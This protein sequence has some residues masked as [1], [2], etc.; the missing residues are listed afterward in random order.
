MDDDEYLRYFEVSIVRE[1]MFYYAD[2]AM[3]KFMIMYAVEHDLMIGAW[4]MLVCEYPN[5]RHF[6]RMF[7][8]WSDYLRPDDNWLCNHCTTPEEANDREHLVCMA[9]ISP[10]SV[11]VM[12][13]YMGDLTALNAC[14]WANFKR[15]DE[16]SIRHELLQQNLEE[17]ANYLVRD[18]NFRSGSTVTCA[19]DVAAVAELQEEETTPPTHVRCPCCVVI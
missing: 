10:E 15:G 6:N 4:F 5:W 9:F 13:A 12:A 16:L 1:H 14:L 11:M 19:E 18:H 7:P 17:Y 8:D 3:C 2:D